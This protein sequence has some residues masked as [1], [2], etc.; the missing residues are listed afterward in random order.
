MFVETDDMS[1]L[2]DLMQPYQGYWDI[3]I[4]PVM[5]LE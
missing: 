2:R 1:K 5:N 4:T 3:T